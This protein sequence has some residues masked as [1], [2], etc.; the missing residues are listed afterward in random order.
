MSGTLKMADVSLPYICIDE[1]RHGNVRIYF[2]RR[3]QRKVRIHAALGTPEFLEAYRTLRQQS[4]LA[5]LG[6]V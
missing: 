3:G 5:S 1:D 6:V 4:E 2:R